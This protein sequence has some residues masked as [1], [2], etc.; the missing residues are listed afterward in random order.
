MNNKR[1]IKKKKE[2]YRSKK[3]KKKNNRGSTPSQGP[4]DQSAGNTSIDAWLGPVRMTSFNTPLNKQVLQHGQCK[5]ET[6]TV[7]PVY[8]LFFLLCSMHSV[9]DPGIGGK[10]VQM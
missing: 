7:C 6:L 2:K 1:K 3:K 8:W 9:T 4:S 10:Y 5:G